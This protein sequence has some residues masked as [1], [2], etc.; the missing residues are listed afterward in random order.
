MHAL[1]FEAAMTDWEKI[2]DL[3]KIRVALWVKEKYL[4]SLNATT[5]EGIRNFWTTILYTFAHNSL[6]I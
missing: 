5:R 3:I 1:I 4:W 2:F 6:G